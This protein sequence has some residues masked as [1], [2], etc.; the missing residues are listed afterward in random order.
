MSQYP[1]LHQGTPNDDINNYQHNTCD[2]NKA[3]TIIVY[4]LT[5][6]TLGKR[7]PCCRG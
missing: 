7:C 6:C 1:Y 5:D 3:L 2:A 4:W